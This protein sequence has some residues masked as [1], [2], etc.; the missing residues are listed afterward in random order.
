MAYS[1][2]YGYSGT[3]DLIVRLK[4]KYGG[5]R[6]LT[7]IKT[8]A[9]AMSGPQLSA[10]ET[11]YRERHKYRGKMDRHV[12]KLPKS[13]DKFKFLPETNRGDFRFFLSKL[14]IYNFMKGR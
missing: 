11:L 13:G 12:L 10:Y 7:D 6:S 1:V 14:A 2:K 9:H 3:W 4:R 5:R 8:G